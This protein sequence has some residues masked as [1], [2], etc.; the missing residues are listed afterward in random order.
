MYLKYDGSL[1]ALKNCATLELM[2]KIKAAGGGGSGRA[3]MN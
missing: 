3:E 2:L 1:V